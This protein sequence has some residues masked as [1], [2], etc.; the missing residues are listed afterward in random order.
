LEEAD[1]SKVP[2]EVEVPNLISIASLTIAS[3]D[4]AIVMPGA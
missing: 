1:V 2:P 3:S 4:G